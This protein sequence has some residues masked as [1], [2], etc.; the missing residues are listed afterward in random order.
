MKHLIFA[1]LILGFGTLHAASASA[2]CF[3]PIEPFCAASG[4]IGNSFITSTDCRIKIEAHLKK[5]TRYQGCLEA[6]IVDSQRESETYRSLL[7][8]PIA[9]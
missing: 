5:L 1:G 9:E 4:N 3:K 6:M 2:N 8:K 7:A